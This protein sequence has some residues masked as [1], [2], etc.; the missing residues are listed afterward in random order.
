ME[1]LSTPTKFENSNFRGYKKYWLADG[2]Y[3]FKENYYNLF[4]K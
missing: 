2:Y 3:Q 4:D 1:L